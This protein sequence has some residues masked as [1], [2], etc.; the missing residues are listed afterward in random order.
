MVSFTYNIRAVRLPQNAI[1]NGSIAIMTP[2]I[3]NLNIDLGFYSTPEFREYYGIVKSR[4]KFTL[5]IDESSCYYIG[6]K[7]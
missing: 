5:N 4:S 1:P 2:R 3:S 6:I 7:K